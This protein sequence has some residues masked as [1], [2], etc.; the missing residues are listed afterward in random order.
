MSIV[1]RSWSNTTRIPLRIAHTFGI[2][3]SCKR[4]FSN[5]IF[6]K[7]PYRY[8]NIA[9]RDLSKLIIKKENDIVLLRKKGDDTATPILTKRLKPYGKIQT[10]RG[11]IDQASLIGKSIRD[12]VP[13]NKRVEY[14]IH[15]PTLAEYVT[16]C[17]RIVTPVRILIMLEWSAVYSS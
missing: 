9:L 3:L 12:V 7:G 16:L 2:C 15:R 1:S 17:P 8:L 13:T 6:I 10:P 11:S 4:Q 14:R 5:K